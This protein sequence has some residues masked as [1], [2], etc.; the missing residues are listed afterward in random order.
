MRRSFFICGC[1]V[2]KQLV[3]IARGPGSK[4]GQLSKR[5]GGGSVPAR[6]KRCLEYKAGRCQLGIDNG[7]CGERITAH[8]CMRPGEIRIDPEP[9]GYRKA[10]WE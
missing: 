8:S 1:A 10:W 4:P 2:E 7:K 9:Q 6:C 5:L 3:S